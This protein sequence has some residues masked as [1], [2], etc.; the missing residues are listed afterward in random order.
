MMLG[1]ILRLDP[2]PPLVWRSPTSLQIGVDPV[3]AVLPRVDDAD[4]RMIGALGTGVTRSGLDVVAQRAGAAPSRVEQLLAELDSVLERGRAERST[5]E[6]ILVVGRGLGASRIADTLAEAGRTVRLSPE[7][8]SSPDA[9][10]SR[11]ALDVGVLIARHVVDP[12]EHLAWLRRDAAHLPVLFGEFGVVI[13]PLV[14][15]GESA[16][17]GCIS[18]HRT[19]ADP[20]W[21]AISAQLLGKEAAAETPIMATRAA[22]EVIAMLEHAAGESVSIR[23]DALSGERTIT[24]VAPHTRCGCRELA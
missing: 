11:A 24:A 18:L 20:A 23:L 21:P 10:P 14:V 3:R 4:V 22:L 2:R 8:L 5:R 13:G 16:C 1:M 15:P 17:L 19:D 7:G 12:S 6:P 9:V